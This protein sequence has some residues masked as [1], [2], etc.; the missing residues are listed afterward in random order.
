MAKTYNRFNHNKLRGRDRSYADLSAFSDDERI[1]M[2]HELVSEETHPRRLQTLMRIFFPKA[3]TSEA[4]KTAPRH[5]TQEQML[6]DARQ[7]AKDDPRWFFAPA[8]PGGLNPYAKDQVKVK[9]RLQAS[10]LKTLSLSGGKINPEQNFLKNIYQWID[11]KLSDQV[12]ISCFQILVFS[13]DELEKH[14]ALE[15]LTP[16][17]PWQADVLNRTSA[18]RRP[19]TKENIHQTILDAYS[20]YGADYVF[21]GRGKPGR[22][23]NPPALQAEP[24]E[25]AGA[26][27]SSIQ[28]PT[29][30]SIP[31]LTKATIESVDYAPERLEANAREV[32]KI[33]GI[34][35]DESF[36]FSTK[37]A[38]DDF[39]ELLENFVNEPQ[40]LKPIDKAVFTKAKR[41]YDLTRD[42]KAL[43]DYC[44]N[45]YGQL[46]NLEPPELANEDQ[47][48]YIHDGS[49]FVWDSDAPFSENA[50][51]DLNKK[52]FAHSVKVGMSI[53]AHTGAVIDCQLESGATP[54][55]N[56]IR[57]SAVATKTSRTIF[58]GDRAYASKENLAFFSST[59]R[60]FI[61]HT[62]LAPFFKEHIPQVSEDQR[63][64]HTSPTYGML[65]HSVELAVT[66]YVNYLIDDYT[67]HQ[68]TQS[69]AYCQRVHQRD[70]E[71]VNLDLKAQYGSFSEITNAYQNKRKKA[72]K[73]YYSQICEGTT[74]YFLVHISLA[75][76]QI[77]A[78]KVNC[79]AFN[80]LKPFE[81]QGVEYRAYSDKLVYACYSISSLEKVSLVYVIDQAENCK[82]SNQSI[83]K[84]AILVEELNSGVK[85]TK[86]HQ[87]LLDAGAIVKLEDGSYISDVYELANKRLAKVRC[88]ITNLNSVHFTIANDRGSMRFAEFIYSIY[89]RRWAIE[90]IFK[91]LKRISNDL[92][93]KSETHIATVLAVMIASM[94]LQGLA[95]AYTFAMTGKSIRIED[96]LNEFTGLAYASS[97]DGLHYE[98]RDHMQASKLMKFK[99]K[100]GLEFPS[101]RTLELHKQLVHKEDTIMHIKKTKYLN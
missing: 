75:T 20:L 7:C 23:A 86:Q 84:T 81:Y 93:A 100:T 21:A 79:K 27:K 13:K 14:K 64:L 44:V 70:G 4:T 96:V 57:Q 68:T 52:V 69:S 22:K 5:K 92:N 101:A 3:A 48:F 53:H 49:H 47:D 59:K 28:A 77:A 54:D 80:T 29:E 67:P 95:R 71:N 99:R 40:G 56:L 24:A 34:E 97:Y 63:V 11:H 31:A 65:M 43:L 30:S 35:A 2:L 45:I 85:P 83:T 66:D 37:R 73:S 88:Y 18:G 16:G 38:T 62:K 61:L 26:T 60:N 90:I 74:P 82:S 12:L 51:T 76:S 58:T 17:I 1:A 50:P 72:G 41:G 89:R 91:L 39:F 8:S 87:A 55:V 32:L 78:L 98:I 36:D 9:P 6:A 10:S 46:T 19:K 15:L 33:I 42:E 25:P 94:T